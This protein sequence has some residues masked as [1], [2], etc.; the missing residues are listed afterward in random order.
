MQKSKLLRLHSF[1]GLVTGIFIFLL[2][3]SGAVLVF[4]TELDNLQYPA[5]IDNGD[6]VISIDSCYNSLQQHYP[7]AQIS[8]LTLAENRTLPF[9]FTIYDSSYISGTRAM[10]V[11]IHPQN[12]RLLKTR[13]GAEDFRN[14]F[15][16]WLSSFHNS[17]RLHKKGEWLLGFLA[18]V[19][20][21]SIITGIILYRKNVL[22]V[23]LFRKSIFKKA[24]LH[25]IIG[26]YALLFNLMIAGTGLWMQRYVF[27]PAFY[28]SGKYTPL[29]KKSLALFFSVDSAYYEIKKQ[30]PGFNAAVIYFAQSKKGMTAVYGYNSGNAFIHS[31]KFADVIFLDS[32]GTLA[33]TAFV[34]E[35]PAGD[36]FDIINSQM[37]QGQ[38]G[39]RV[40]KIIYCLFGFTGGLL[41]IT[42]F[43]IW[44]RK[45]YQT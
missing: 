14:H 43:L 15:M 35:I 23:L 1:T 10:Q 42:G 13:G 16:G 9:I 38:Y 41:S 33:S 17:F 45:K 36:Q 31:K 20:L 34:N 37:H 3:V 11:F 6:P 28:T 25:Q 22:A 2:S 19:F 21:L 30:Y 5:V 26:T 8:N 40:I 44:I 39:G 32:T 24:N 4:H 29:L 27:K 7:K 18:I 12:G